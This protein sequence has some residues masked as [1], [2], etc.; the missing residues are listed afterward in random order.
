MIDIVHGFIENYICYQYITKDML[1]IFPESHVNVLL[2][3]CCSV[4]GFS[5]G[6]FTSKYVRDIGLESE[7]YSLIKKN[8]SIQEKLDNKLLDDKVYYIYNDILKIVEDKLT[9]EKVLDKNFNHND[10]AS[11]YDLELEEILL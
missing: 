9:N 5:I 2:T 10:I 7:I 8:Q 6:L 3:L 11:D 4:L 1:S